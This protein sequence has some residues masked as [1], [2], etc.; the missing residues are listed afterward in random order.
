MVVQ[1][2]QLSCFPF[3]QNDGCWNMLEQG[4]FVKSEWMVT[5]YDEIIVWFLRDFPFR[6]LNEYKT[7]RR[8]PTPTIS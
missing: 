3:Q 1:N 5:K 8:Y 6:T 2:A 7:K 4:A